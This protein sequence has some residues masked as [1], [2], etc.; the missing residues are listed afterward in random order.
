L[1]VCLF[2]CLFFKA[3]KQDDFLGFSFFRLQ[4]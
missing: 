1:V 2:V 4:H 3:C